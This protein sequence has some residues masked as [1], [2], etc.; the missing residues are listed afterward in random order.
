MSKILWIRFLRSTVPLGVMAVSLTVFA[1]CTGA[2]STPTPQPTATATH[3]SAAATTPQPTATATQVPAAT[4]TRSLYAAPQGGTQI[5]TGS[6]G[7]LGTVLVGPDGHTLYAYDNDP[8]G[9]STCAGS[10]ASTWPPLT[11][12][13]NV[14]AAS[15][16]TGTLSTIT[17]SDGTK[18]AAINGK[19]LYYYSGDS[20][21]GD[22]N[23]QGKGSV[24]A[25]VRQDGSKVLQYR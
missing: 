3:V 21:P 6:A 13:G 10:C 20:K 23:G 12:T 16:V 15:T 19:P 7:A 4:A 9:Q 11:A 2:K 24:W 8:S 17:R 5:G 25:A 18:Q 1:G 14:S 22:A